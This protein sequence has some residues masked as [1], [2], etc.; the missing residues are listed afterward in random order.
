MGFSLV[1]KIM[2]NMSLLDRCTDNAMYCGENLLVLVNNALNTTDVP[3][4]C[5]TVLP[6]STS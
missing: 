1:K 6:W 4:F 5:M 3:Q 2:K